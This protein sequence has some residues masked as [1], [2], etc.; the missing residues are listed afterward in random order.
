VNLFVGGMTLA[1]Q[2]GDRSN[3]TIPELIT[4]I[5]EFV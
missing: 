2:V 4:R 1:A 3:E 5:V